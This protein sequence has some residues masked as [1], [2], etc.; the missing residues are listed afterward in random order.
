MRTAADAVH[1]T[2]IDCCTSTVALRV[3]YCL[4]L[5]SSSC[6]QQQRLT[7]NLLQLIPQQKAALQVRSI[8][9]GGLPESVNEEKLQNVF[10]VFGEVRASAAKVVCELSVK[11]VAGFAV[12]MEC[13]VHLFQAGSLQYSVVCLVLH[14]LT[15]R[16]FNA[17]WLLPHA[18]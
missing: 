3:A 16:L 12:S 14:R 10:K 9:I 4:E 5:L 2:D 18:D 1:C 13:S 17:S 15:D 6:C 7:W 8:F 11:L